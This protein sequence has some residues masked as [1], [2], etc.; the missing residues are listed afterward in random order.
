MCIAW[1]SIADKT[2]RLQLVMEYFPL[3]SL[4]KYL[5]EKKDKIPHKTLYLFAQQI[6]QVRL[7]QFVD[8]LDFI[9]GMANW[10]IFKILPNFQI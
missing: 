8:N 2:N 5:R 9:S 7:P 1:C 4:E 3:G 6:C 10:R